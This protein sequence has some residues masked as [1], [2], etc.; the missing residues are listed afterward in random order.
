MGDVAR[1]YVVKTSWLDACAKNA[2]ACETYDTA[3]RIANAIDSDHAAQ[4]IDELLVV[5]PVEVA[6]DGDS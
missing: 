5:V 4:L 3:W 1:I 6:R 2:V